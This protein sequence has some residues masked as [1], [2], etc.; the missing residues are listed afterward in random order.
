MRITEALTIETWIYLNRLGP[1]QSIITFG[2]RDAGFTESLSNNLLY[3]IDV[4]GGG[5]LRVLHERADLSDA[6]VLFDTN[7][8][9]GL[10]YH[11][12][13]TRTIV[14]PSMVEYSIL[15][16]DRAP[17]SASVS[18]LPAGGTFGRLLLGR[19]EGNF[20]LPDFFDRPFDGFVADMRIW[21]RVRTAEEILDSM[22]LS[23]PSD[24]TGLVALWPM[25]ALTG[26]RT[27]DVV[28][29]NHFDAAFT[30]GTV[31]VGSD[32]NQNLVPDSCDPDCN[33]N[34][35]PDECDIR[36]GTS[37]DCNG[38][39]VPEECD[40]L[41][42]MNDIFNPAERATEVFRENRDRPVS[43]TKFGTMIQLYGRPWKPGTG[44]TPGGGVC[45]E[46]SR[47]GLIC[48]SPVDCPEGTCAPPPGTGDVRDPAERLRMV[49]RD[50]SCL[51]VDRAQVALEQLFAFEM[52]LGNE[53][54]SDAL[55]PTV[56]VGTLD[57]MISLEQVPGMFAFRGLPAVQSLLDEELALLR[58]REI[59]LP[60]SSNLPL[61]D[62]PPNN[63]NG[64]YPLFGMA[65]HRAAIYNRLR[66]NAENALDSIAYRSNYGLSN[67]PSNA[68]A[69]EVFPQ[70]HGDAFGYF[71]T[72]S[73]QYLNTFGARQEMPVSPDFARRFIES[74][75]VPA[76]SASCVQMDCE[77]IVDD[78]GTMHHVGFQSVR[79]M[80]AAMAAR[81]RTV[82]RIVDL[83]FRQEYREDVD[84]RLVDSD[85][86]RGWGIADWGRR[87]GVGAYLDWA[88]LNHLLP[89]P[90]AGAVD[91]VESVHRERVDEVRILASAVKEMQ[92][93]V[94]AAGAGLNPLGLV[95]NVVPF[96]IIQPGQLLN[97]LEGGAS[98]GKSHYGIVRD[99]AVEAIR[100]A[101]GI[102]QRANLGLNRLRGNETSF[103]DFEDQL[104]ESD[105]G[106]TN[107]LIEIFGLPSVDD[108]AD[109]DLQD[110]DGDGVQLTL[111]VNDPDDDIIE[112]GCNGECAGS[113][114]LQ[115]FLL[116]SQALEEL[117]FAERA[118]VG[119]VQLAM[120]EFR[121]A[122]L[123]GQV[124]DLAIS[125]LEAL[126]QAKAE[127]VALTREEAIETLEIQAT[128][129][130][131]RLKVLD[132]KK[133]LAIARAES[134]LFGKFVGFI[135]GAAT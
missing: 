103:T 35:I 84:T 8:H 122:V 37:A 44:Q 120:F 111:G 18:G 28:G 56:G 94:D 53:A 27:L 40:F 100:N 108:T 1:T 2:E 12:A 126:I 125:N 81:A 121:N 52:L 34:S 5:D 38:N 46:G 48:N 61:S 51:P 127:N 64:N 133:S 60:V 76:G 102:L 85:V 104:R 87:G 32:C 23:M 101:R 117:G 55:D 132:R 19:G 129:C 13:L 21:N 90:E 31:T 83:T 63:I 58:G 3:A 33:G 116:D 75:H 80:A 65:E 92:E 123:K 130:N 14:S 106:A 50:P 88:A 110:N 9:A 93:R 131:D 73:K 6:A 77:D 42:I 17:M 114:D 79:S 66:P 72:A 49:T 115:S 62:D 86:A 96:R 128:A 95:S 10:W 11:I 16:N 57:D 135:K 39:G 113:P 82:N 26:N 107:K 47:N 134:G 4:D 15:I 99:A 89:V 97:F 20:V 67:T 24:S 68:T 45:L 59:A 71:L 22:F 43:P 105:V 74:Q 30:I 69:S 78:L 41:D 54:F 70:G 109:N 91:E 98:S 7:L 29:G 25:D 124:A 36:M 112:A 119:Q 118:A